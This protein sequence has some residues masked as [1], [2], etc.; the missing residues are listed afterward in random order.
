MFTYKQ[1][2][3]MDRTPIK[4]P[5]C[6]AMMLQTEWPT[7]CN[8]QHGPSMRGKKASK[9]ERKRYKLHGPVASA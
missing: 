1:Q 2:K 7:H 9:R 4:C 5:Y 6:D 3:Q 8:E